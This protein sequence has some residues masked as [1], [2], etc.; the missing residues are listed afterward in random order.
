MPGAP[1][2]KASL[3]HAGEG[4]QALVWHPDGQHVIYGAGVMIVI[5]RVDPGNPRLDQ[6]ILQ[7]RGWAGASTHCVQVKCAEL[8]QSPCVALARAGASLEQR[9]GAR[10]SLAQDKVYQ[11]TCHAVAACGGRIGNTKPTGPL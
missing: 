2:S 8:G 9:R 11:Y 10:L 4:S 7:V 6:R 1:E 3:C 5:L